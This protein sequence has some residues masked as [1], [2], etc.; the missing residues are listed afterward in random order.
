MQLKIYLFLLLMYKSVQKCLKKKKPERLPSL[1]AFCKKKKKVGTK[2]K[3]SSYW[4]KFDNLGIQ[5]ISEKVELREFKHCWQN[6][7]IYFREQLRVIL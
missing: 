7:Q 4:H 2:T 5:S 6:W 3:M 1:I